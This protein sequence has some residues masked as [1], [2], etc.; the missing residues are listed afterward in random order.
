MLGRDCGNVFTRDYILDYSYDT[1]MGI[2]YALG[3]EKITSNMI[4]MRQRI[5]SRR[6]APFF[7]LLT[8]CYI[9]RGIVAEIAL[10]ET[11]QSDEGLPVAI[12][13]RKPPNSFFLLSPRLP[14]SPT[15]VATRT[16]NN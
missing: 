16:I 6:K 3:L 10:A 5:L 8:M 7:L 15:F 13:P 14:L 2:K 4:V 11:N 12:L 1:Y 9:N